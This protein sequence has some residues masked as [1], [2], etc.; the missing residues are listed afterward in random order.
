VHKRIIAKSSLFQLRLGQLSTSFLGL[1]LTLTVVLPPAASAKVPGAVH[2]YND[3][4]HRIRTV[5]E[6]AARR[7]IVEPVVASFYD[8]P[9]NDRFNPRTE[10]SSGTEFDA[11]ASDNA[12]SPI[13]PDGT[14]LLVWSPATGGAA[15]VRIDN[16]GPY[17]PGRTLDLSRGAAERLGFARG[18]VMQLLSVVISA[19]SDPEARYVRGRSYPKVRGY[20]GKF[21]NIALAS[22]EDQTARMAVFQGNAPLP[23][24]ALTS[25]PTKQLVMAAAEK[26]MKSTALMQAFSSAPAEVIEPPVVVA[27]LSE[28]TAAVAQAAATE[29][30]HLAAAPA[31]TQPSVRVATL[32]MPPKAPPAAVVLP[33][34]TS[35]ADTARAIVKRKVAEVSSRDEDEPQPRSPTARKAPRPPGETAT[36]LVSHLAGQAAGFGWAAMSSN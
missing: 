16:A 10:T 26:H 11:D 13:H 21:D 2:C 35:T 27:D 23:A 24:L 32:S 22:L 4:C 5:E 12:A 36:S 9:A 6:T 1:V 19:P 34:E 30:L 28:R 18:G 25:S 31:P 7:G 33:S 15:I 29:N 3:I 17:Y 20:L 8:W 14:V